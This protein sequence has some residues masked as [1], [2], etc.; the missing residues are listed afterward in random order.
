MAFRRTRS[1]VLGLLVTLAAIAATASLV[2]PLGAAGAPAKTCASRATCQVIGLS[3]QV[4]DSAGFLVRSDGAGPYINGVDNVS[5]QLTAGGA[6]RFDTGTVLPAVRTMVSQYNNPLPGSSAYSPLLQPGA[7]YYW[8]NVGVVTIAIQEL[9]VAAS[10]CKPAYFKTDDGL[11]FYSTLYQSG[12]EGSTGPTGQWL[13]TRISAN[14]WTVETSSICAGDAV[15]LRHQLP[16]TKKG[17]A[18]DWE[19]IGYYHLP[20]KLILTA[21]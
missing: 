3:V 9:Q 20:F 17:P 2:V 4:D 15:N 7:H 18:P 5:A 21:Q 11:E 16:I 1:A 8:Q 10:M 6:F 12:I 13:I 14:T 19:T